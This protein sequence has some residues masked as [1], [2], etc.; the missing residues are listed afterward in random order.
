MFKSMEEQLN[1]II[2]RL[3]YNLYTSPESHMIF[4]AFSQ[5]CELLTVFSIKS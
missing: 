5:V 1:N 2:T 3:L 4:N